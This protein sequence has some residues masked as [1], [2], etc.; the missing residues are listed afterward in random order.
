MSGNTLIRPRWFTLIFTL[1]YLGN[2]KYGPTQPQD[3]KSKYCHWSVDIPNIMNPEDYRQNGCLR[4]THLFITTSQQSSG[5]GLH[6][7]VACKNQD[8]VLFCLFVCLSVLFCFFGQ[9]GFSWWASALKMIFKNLPITVFSL[10]IK[11][12]HEHNKPRES[13][14]W[15]G[16]SLSQHGKQVLLSKCTGQIIRLFHMIILTFKSQQCQRLRSCLPLSPHL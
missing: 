3:H 16:Q 13:H 1:F 7:S 9:K 10:Y 4:S 15:S 8:Q 6:Y 11:Q 12:N 2:F 5:L 14:Y